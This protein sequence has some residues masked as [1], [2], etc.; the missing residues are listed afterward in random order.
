MSGGESG[1]GQRVVGGGE[2]RCSF[3]GV[4]SIA[5]GTA[6]VGLGF[7]GPSDDLDVIAKHV[8]VCLFSDVMC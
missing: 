6:I 4:A 7:V 2:D 5:V 3:V 8:F 1:G